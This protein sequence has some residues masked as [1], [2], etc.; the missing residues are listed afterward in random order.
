MSTKN[1]CKMQKKNEMSTEKKNRE[2][3]TVR[4]Y[5]NNRTRLEPMKSVRLQTLHMDYE[6]YCNNILNRPA[7]TK[8]IFMRELRFVLEGEIS[9]QRILVK[10][11]GP[12]RIVGLEIADLSQ[13]TWPAQST[14]TTGDVLQEQPNAAN[15]Q[16]FSRS[17][18]SSPMAMK[19]R[20]KLAVCRVR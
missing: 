4:D 7:L 13:S 14:L 16:E 19:W 18:S 17:S 5:V 20:Q 3:N 2:I 11:S 10:N 6:N 1:I 8:R 9:T 15:H 12:V